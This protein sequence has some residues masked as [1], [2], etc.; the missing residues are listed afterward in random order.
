MAAACGIKLS[1]CVRFAAGLIDVGVV[2]RSIE[3]EAFSAMISVKNRVNARIMV[4]YGFLILRGIIR[5]EKWE[6]V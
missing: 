4:L 6:H 2:S 5:G 1:E 3:K